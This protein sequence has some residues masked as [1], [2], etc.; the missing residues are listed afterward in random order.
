MSDAKMEAHLELDSD[1]WG[2]NLP[3]TMTV[4]LTNC[5]GRPGISA[6]YVRQQESEGVVV[7]VLGED[8]DPSLAPV[9]VLDRPAAINPG[10]YRMTRIDEQG[11]A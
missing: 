2:D 5:D 3:D 11:E 7:E 9:L 8:V 1:V 10:K 6:D 4:L